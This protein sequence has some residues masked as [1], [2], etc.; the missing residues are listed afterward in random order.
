[1]IKYYNYS[2]IYNVQANFSFQSGD[3]IGPESKDSDGGC[4]IWALPDSTTKRASKPQNATFAPEISSKRKH[5]ERGTLSM[6][7]TVSKTNPDQ[8][9][10]S[11]QFMIT[12]G[13]NLDQLDEKAAI[14]GQVVEGF[15]ALE[16]INTAFVDQSGRPL[17][18]IRILHTVV[19]DDP[20]ADPIGLVKP[21]GSPVPSAEQLATVRIAHDEVLA[22]N[23]DP[24][25]LE[26]VRRE[27]EARAQ[28]L[29]LEL[30]GDLPFADVTPPEQILFVCKL[31]P[32]T[33]DDDLE[34]I[35]SRFGKILS[36]EVIRDKKT[37]DSLQ[38]AFI[39]FATKEDCERAYFKMQGVLIDD[40]RIHVDF[41][42]SVSKISAEWRSNTKSKTARYRGGFGGIDGLEKRQQYRDSGS[43]RDRRRHYDYVFE[44]DKKDKS[45]SDDARH[46]DR[47]NESR[48]Q[49]SRSRS[50]KRRSDWPS[51]DRRDYRRL[52]DRRDDRRSDDYHRDDRRRPSDRERHRDSRDNYRRH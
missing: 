13:E 40:H 39:E 46:T 47:G 6:A 28:A 7:T 33:Q 32:V 23:N 10:A 38:Y 12:L 24:E 25:K 26:Q 42:Q 18:D 43:D 29:T 36:C 45:R 37:G 9:L 4:S 20:Y 34:L 44:K 27:R 51:D 5:T 41:S 17:Q 35:F 15:D 21:P 50:P 19:L 11:S 8:R 52:D 2:P 3:P 22:E 16:K 14:F 48:R 49:R 30:I 31:N 1:M